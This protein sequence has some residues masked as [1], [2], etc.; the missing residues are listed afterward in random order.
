[1]G[2]GRCRGRRDR[3]LPREAR[4]LP[5]VPRESRGELTDALRAADL[6]RQ[7]ELTLEHAL[8]HRADDVRLRLAALEQDH[9][10]DRLDAV[11][12]R[13]VLVLVDV[14]L[15]ELEISLLC[16]ALEDGGDG[17]TRSA[18]LRPEVD[19]H[20]LAALEHLVLEG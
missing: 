20:R 6:L 9:V 3:G 15:D 10:R 12:N 11:A 19:E 1:R 17:V 8:R 7:P 13:Q 5:R 16:D 14:D 2:L 4:S 18:P